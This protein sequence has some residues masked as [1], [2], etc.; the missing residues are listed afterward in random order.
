MK[1]YIGLHNALHGFMH[2]ILINLLFLK[3]K[4]NIFRLQDIHK[5]YVCVQENLSRKDTIKYSPNLT[6]ILSWIVWIHV[7]LSVFENTM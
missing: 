1:L 7:E 2:K 6:D 4:K 5:K 3:K